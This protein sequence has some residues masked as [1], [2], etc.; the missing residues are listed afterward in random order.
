[1]KAMKKSLRKLGK[2][3]RRGKADVPRDPPRLHTSTPSE[4]DIATPPFGQEQ[5]I[6]KEGRQEQSSVQLEQEK[7]ERKTPNDKRAED[8]QEKLEEDE[9]EKQGGGGRDDTAEEE[10]NR[11]VKR[12]E[13]EGEKE[14]PKAENE[15]CRELEEDA[16]E[17]EGKGR[18]EHPEEDA[19]DGS[20]PQKEERGEHKNTAEDVAMESLDE[21]SP[22][23]EQTDGMSVEDDSSPTNERSPEEEQ[24]NATGVEDTTSPTNEHSP[25]GEQT[26]GT[27]VEDATSPT[28][29]RSP[30]EKQ[31]GRT[32]VE[33]ATSPTNEEEG[34]T[35]RL[36]S[37]AKRPTEAPLL[38]DWFIQREPVVAAICDRLG[39]NDGGGSRASG[40]PPV[41]GVAGPSGAGK[42]TIASMIIARDDVRGHFSEKG[43]VWL[44]VGQGA[45]DRLLDVMYRLAVMVHELVV[46]SSSFPDDGPFRPPQT[47]DIGVEPEDGAAYVREILTAEEGE[48][49]SGSFGELLV[50]AD[51]V[52]EAE[53][54]AELRSTGASILYT[55]RS[56]EDL[57]AASGGSSVLQVDEVTEGEA[58]EILRR[59]ADLLDYTKLPDAAHDIIR[60]GG[61]VAMDV[62]YVGRWDIVR[63]KNDQAAWAVVLAHVIDAQN[64]MKGAAL[65][66]WRSAVLR[67]GLTRLGFADQGTKELYLSLGVL[68]RNLS[69]SGDDVTALVSDGSAEELQAATLAIATL[70]QW[71]V[72]M[73]TEGGRYRVH[74]SHADMAWQGISEDPAILGPA[75]AR[76]RNRVS[77]AEAVLAWRTEELVDIWQA[78]WS[79]EIGEG[80]E[81][82]GQ[83]YAEIVDAMNL[84]DA[85]A[86]QLLRRIAFFQWLT[87]EPDAACMSWSKLLASCE[88]ST[89]NHPD[90]HVTMYTLGA[91]A[92]VSGR[93]HEAEGWFRRTLAIEERVLDSDDAAIAD[94]LHEIASCAFRE[95]RMK[96]AE[97]FHLRAL[98]VRESLQGHE[99]LDVAKTLHSLGLCILKMNT[100]AKEAEGYLRR[101]LR[102]FSEKL[103]ATDTKAS[104]AMYDLGR[105]LSLAGQT[106]EAEEYLQRALSIQGNR[107]GLKSPAV[108]DTLY[109]LGGCM[110]D[111]GQP[112]VAGVFYRRALAIREESLGADDP[113]TV[114]TLRALAQVLLDTSNTEEA[115]GLFQRALVGVE[116]CL[117]SSHREVAVLFHGLG[118]CA[119]AEQKPEEAEQQFQRALAIRE[120]SLGA[121]QSSIAHT[122][123]DLGRCASQ[124]GRMEQAEDFYR[125]SL[126]IEEAS[127]GEHHEEVATVL[128]SLSVCVA[129]QG[130]RNKEVE[131]LLERVVEI[132]EINRKAMKP[133]KRND[134]ELADILGGLGAAS[135]RAG[136][137]DA[138]A[139]HIRHALAIYEKAL[140]AHHPKISFTLNALGKCLFKAGRAEEAEVSFRRVLDMTTAEGEHKG[141]EDSVHNC[142]HPPVG[143]TLDFLGQCAMFEGRTEEARR[144]FHRA[145]EGRKDHLGPDHPRV[146]LTL[147]SI[148]RCFFD[149]GNLEEADHHLNCALS[150]QEKTL[151]PEHPSIAATQA[152]RESIKRKQVY[153]R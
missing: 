11:Q 82:I 132:K 135:F 129:E 152:G 17:E 73:R 44:S 24:T 27:K 131:G 85:G 65:L 36:Y 54:L 101:A 38:Q 114:R 141:G 18:E 15:G 128:Y 31:T 26:E 25:E 69:F 80:A 51:D 9:T 12:H 67:V 77:T 60:R 14:G 90:V 117:G 106:R 5:T 16:T 7:G 144:L 83:P 122:L 68:P 151:D 39:V 40:E 153:F 149:E 102:I 33:E 96:E 4:A 57:L 108:A 3:H 74:H 22:E 93:T 121:D 61:P 48:R 146:A 99:H 78:I 45:R 142:S 140:D 53:V 47:P 124:A 37:I 88:D 115:Q 125:R 35:K 109:A 111:A 28:N 110:A 64:F 116:N 32:R 95:G 98:A 136:H 75:L 113:S 123:Y 70:E 34:R 92:L 21:R 2:R 56:E 52:W 118:A 42:S 66:P 148:G 138:A 71:S 72:L 55:T 87:N 50:V 13:E 127:L 104:N 23:E 46:D 107:Q 89:A 84:S 100:R 19:K 112:A 10:G 79:L 133:T 137:L 143:D 97:S 8:G 126:M 20:E 58:E 134:V 49:S 120:R 29:E 1:M 145:L 94:T 62:A 150:I 147:Y 76:W 86:F 81:E 119:L 130:G 59:A 43:V 105:C 41:V 91:H 30:E 6:K 103:G 139:K 63:G